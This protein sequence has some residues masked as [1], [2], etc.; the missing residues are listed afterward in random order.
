MGIVT[1]ELLKHVPK[2][3]M[4]NKET[5]HVKVSVDGKTDD[6][7]WMSKNDITEILKDFH[8]HELQDMLKLDNI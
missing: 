2:R 1:F 4:R 3:K 5:V 8:S 7:L 6:V